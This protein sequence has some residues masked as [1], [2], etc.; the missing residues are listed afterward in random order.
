MYNFLSWFVYGFLS[1]FVWF[2]SG[3]VV[4]VG[5]MLGSIYYPRAKQ[6][7]IP[8]IAK[9]STAPRRE[10]NSE[11]LAV[12]KMT[13][14]LTKNPS[15]MDTNIHQKSDHMLTS[16]FHRFFVGFGGFGGPSWSP[17]CIKNGFQTHMKRWSKKLSK[18][19]HAV[20]SK[21]HASRGLWVP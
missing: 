3:L 19:S 17:K 8:K 11:G 21:G 4:Q 18:K 7:Q 15:K 9:I 14:K 13:T 20:N 5:A 12:L 6:N 16:I 2:W 10:L 1:I